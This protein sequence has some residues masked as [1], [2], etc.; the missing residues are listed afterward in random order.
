[1]PSRKPRPDRP[2]GPRLKR[3]AKRAERVS[4][5]PLHE[6]QHPELLERVRAR[7]L[8]LPETSEKIAWGRPTF[9]VKGKLFVM[10]LED[11]HGDGRLA[12]WCNAF[13]EAREALL[14]ADAS[15]FFVPPYM[16]PSGWIG[17]RLDKRLPWSRVGGVI[18]DAWRRSAP[19]KLSALLEGD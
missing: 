10:Y 5:H 14:A 9:R 3:G 15:R 4:T 2:L 18:T 11:H 16:G 19:S 8:A 12:I 7:C 6:T 1:M 17:V 13:P